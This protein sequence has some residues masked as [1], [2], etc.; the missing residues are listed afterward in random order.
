[1]MGGSLVE[2]NRLGE[3]YEKVYKKREVI[4]NDTA[5]NKIFDIVKGVYS[6]INPTPMLIKSGI[7]G[8]IDA[9]QY[10]AAISK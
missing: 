7:G 8:L 9:F 3:I 4:D 5:A 10:S 1:M 2:A 6:F